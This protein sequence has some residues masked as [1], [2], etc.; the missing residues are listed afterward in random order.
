MKRQNHF[1]SSGWDN[2]V[3]KAVVQRSRVN[4]AKTDGKGLQ[5]TF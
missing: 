3:K 5:R 4:K 2:K 1:E